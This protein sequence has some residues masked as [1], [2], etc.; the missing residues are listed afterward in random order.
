[1]DTLTVAAINV[2]GLR[3]VQ[4]SSKA[5]TICHLFTPP[6]NDIV[7]LLDTRLDP[8]TE[9][10]ITSH[11]TSPVLFAHN[12]FA[13]TNGIAILFPTSSAKVTNCIRDAYG[14]YAILDVEIRDHKL[15]I[16]PVYAPAKDPV[17]RKIFF[18]HLHQQIQLH[19]TALHNIILL[20]DFNVTENDVLDRATHVPR[21]DPSLPPLKRIQTDHHL[22][23]FWRRSHPDAQTYT[24]QG[25]QGALARLDRIYTSRQ[26]RNL[27]L[28]TDIVPFVHSDHDMVQIT[29]RTSTLLHGNG[30]W[31]LDKDILQERDYVALITS[32]CSSWHAKKPTFPSLLTWWDAFKLRI[33]NVSKQYTRTRSLQRKAYRRSLDRRLKS[34]HRRTHP[35]P[36]IQQFTL[37]LQQKKKTL[38]EAQAQRQVLHAKAQW[39]E[40]GE[41]CSK[42]FLNL[43][44]KRKQDTT[45][46]ALTVSPTKT[47]TTSAEIVQETKAYYQTLYTASPVSENLQNILLAKLPSA[48]TPAR[49][50]SCDGPITA[51]ELKNATHNSNRNKSPGCDGLPLEFYLTFF[52]L[53]KDDFLQVANSIPTD[54]SLSPTQRNALITCLPK[55]GDLSLLKN[56]RPISLLNTDYKIISKVIA[57]RLYKVLPTIISEDQTCNLHNRKIQYNLSLIRDVIAFANSTQQPYCLLTI[58]QMKAFDRVDWGFLHKILVRLRFG[59]DFQHW[60]H[61]LYH[62]ITSQVKVNGY[63]SDP[64]SLHQGVRQGC[65]LSPLLYV[66]YAEVLAENI[67]Q[68]PHITGISI[69]DVTCTV[70]QYA[71]DTTLFLKNDA[72]IIALH[73]LLAVFQTA[74]GAIVN[75]DKCHGLWLGSNRHRLDSPLHYQWSSHHIKIL[76]LVFGDQASMDSNFYTAAEK[77]YRTLH[78]WTPRHL[79]M[80]G[81]KIV[82]NQLAQ[83]QLVYPSHVFVCPAPIVTQLHRATLS[84]FNNNKRIHVD[85]A[86]L[87]LPVPLGGFGLLAT[88]RKMQAT[89]LTWISRLFDTRCKGKWRATM[90]HF[91][92][93]YRDL[94][95]G[96]NVFKTFISCH[97]QTLLPLPPFYRTLFLD[98][99]ALTG[100]QR[101]SPTSLACIY[102]EPIF[103]NPLLAEARP[104]PALPLPLVPPNWYRRY[105][106]DN[107]R[108]LGD[109]CHQYR[110]GFHTPPELVEL[111]GYP[112]IAHF[113][114]RVTR[115][116]PASW[117]NSIQS[118]P[119]PSTPSNAI[120]LTLTDEFNEPHI[121]DVHSLTSRHLYL[122]NAPKTFSRI[123]MEKDLNGVVIYTNWERSFGR[124]SWSKVFRFMYNNHVDKPTTDIQYKH[125]HGKLVSRITLHHAKLQDGSLCTR[126]LQFPENLA[127]I[128]LECVHSRHLWN[129][130]IPILC[131]LTGLPRLRFLSPKLIVVGFV[132]EMLSPSHLQAVEDVRSAFFFAV[133]TSRNASMW[134]RIDK[135]ALPLFTAR[136]AHLLA[137]RYTAAFLHRKE[138][139]VC[140]LY[141]HNTLFSVLNGRITVLM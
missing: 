73:N 71:D 52:D 19:T 22:E 15:L 84:F 116:M 46:H 67:R 69:H 23:D 141:A 77:Y 89:R 27:I 38:E 102:Q 80:K 74:T 119:T 137:L 76:G 59:A 3:A 133:W 115:N 16:I 9:Q 118:S 117:Y 121:V 99:V 50:A 107:L 43:A 101:R 47:V 94:H 138:H 11:W 53:L 103:H 111:T 14:R 8:L 83:S 106:A 6:T 48:L 78:L 32:L 20:G 93:A 26:F 139:E 136:L 5:A 62:N 44:K 45:I 123:Q 87:S 4:S 109:I 95:L 65:P 7:C 28:K 125:I 85:P 96:E 13:H 64:F 25:A 29:L 55:E 132:D 126:C 68:D 34:L 33:K 37:H 30:V 114:N 54:G 104:P 91:L 129:H 51:K 40:E 35:S 110:P 66:L 130:L 135:P 134:D 39:V 100:N 41:R 49:A 10:R 98:W 1:M 36:S 2:N 12:T 63:L 17:Q 58:D 81:K 60:V 88:N 113:I 112:R 56:W 140:A 124:I 21:K 42:Y 120:R 82:I 97:R 90:R 18:Q 92:N 105:L 128:F 122:Y 24:F 79:S 31:K 72:S 61:I 86:I 127:H 70:S 57:E 131:L 108:T 75:P